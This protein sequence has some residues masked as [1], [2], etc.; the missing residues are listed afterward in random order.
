[1]RQLGKEAWDRV[2]ERCRRRREPQWVLRQGDMTK[3]RFGMAS[4]V[5]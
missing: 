4:S 1:M 2:P 5:W 3:T